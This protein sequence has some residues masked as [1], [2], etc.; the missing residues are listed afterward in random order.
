MKELARFILM[1]SFIAY[2][3]MKWQAIKPSGGP[4]PRA[5]A[6]PNPNEG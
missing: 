3:H 6:N 1:V 2:R 5:R 4:A